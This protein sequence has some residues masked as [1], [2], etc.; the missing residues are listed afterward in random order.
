MKTVLITIACTLGATFALLL[1]I[2]IYEMNHLPQTYTCE[3][4]D[5]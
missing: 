2:V 3:R 5:A 1:A 4:I